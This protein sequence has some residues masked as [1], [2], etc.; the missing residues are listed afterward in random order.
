[1]AEGDTIHRNARR[2]AAALGDEPL[3]RAEAPSPRS[4]LRAQPQRLAALVGRRL[5]RADAHGKH[6]FLRFEGD[7]VLHSHQGMN[8]S[9]HT[10]RPGERWG[11]P[12]GAAW[13][14]LATD[15]VEAVEF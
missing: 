1:M 10:Y 14:V 7:L 13:A 5:E 8:G 12:R 4:S 3:I 11:K 15:R 6:L 9:W 2:L